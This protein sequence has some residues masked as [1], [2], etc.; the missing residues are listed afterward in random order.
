MKTKLGRPMRSIVSK[1]AVPVFALHLCITLFGQLPNEGFQRV[2]SRD[3]FS[4]VP[5]WRFF[6]P[7]PARADYQIFMRA[8]S[9]ECASSWHELHVPPPRTLG[10]LFWAPQHREQKAVFDVVTELMRVFPYVDG[11]SVNS[12][13]QYRLLEAHIVSEARL[14]EDFATHDTVQFTIL[15]TGGFDLSVDPSI[16]FISRSISI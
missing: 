6:A 11:D 4:L 12:L 10:H 5:T 16:L 15:A 7:V 3:Y 2:R 8:F 13:P 9:A 1:L 14:I